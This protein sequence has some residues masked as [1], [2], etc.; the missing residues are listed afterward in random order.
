MPQCSVLGL[1]EFIAYTDNLECL[2]DRHHLGHHLY[3]DYTQLIDGVRIAEINATID[4]LQLCMEDIH[5]WCASRRLQLNPTKT[6]VIW[7]GTAASLRKIMNTDLTLHVGCDVI[8]PVSVHGACMILVYYW[9][10][11]YP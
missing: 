8:K 1:Q 11:N 6:E 4:R 10:K 9:F 7:F 5:R 2:I 3:A